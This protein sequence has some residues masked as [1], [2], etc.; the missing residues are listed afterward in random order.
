MD[1]F[2]LIDEASL[3]G[4]REAQS[5]AAWAQPGGPEA[6]APFQTQIEGLLGE[7]AEPDA[8]FFVDSWTVGVAAAQENF[9]RRH[10][11]TKRRDHDLP[12]WD[13]FF[14][15]TP[16]FVARVEASAETAW[17]LNESRAAEG[18]T[19]D[20]RWPGSEPV[21]DSRAP[22]ETE[23]VCPLTLESACKVLGVA[24]TSTREQI[25]ARYRQMASR[26]HPDRLVRG[27]D[28][29]Q[30]LASDRM[31]SINEAYRLLCAGL[32]ERWGTC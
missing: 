8:A 21:D 30:K 25:R 14:S 3:E 2:W 29:E 16:F 17:P 22:N 6:G 1:P 9:L 18:W 13:S 24:V 12:R 10:E 5:G 26:Y 15:C 11:A 31:A 19:A 23:M 4:A 27:G 7:E 20:P 28:R 32:A